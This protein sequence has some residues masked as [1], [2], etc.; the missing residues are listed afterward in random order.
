M[1]RQLFYI[2]PLI[3][4]AASVF[5]GSCNKAVVDRT[6]LYPALAPANIDLNADTWKPVLITGSNRIYCS[7]PGCYRLACLHGGYK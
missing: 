4:L 1:K 2:M 3:V 5:F 6:T 7:G